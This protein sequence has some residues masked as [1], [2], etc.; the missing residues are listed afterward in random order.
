MKIPHDKIT[1]SEIDE[2]YTQS[3]EEIYLYNCHG[4]VWNNEHC[5]SFFPY[6]LVGKI[7][8]LYKCTSNE[9]LVEVHE[10]YKSY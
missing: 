9:K 7:L 10:S 4:V 2:I 1:L 8:Y 3:W 5:Q 6:I